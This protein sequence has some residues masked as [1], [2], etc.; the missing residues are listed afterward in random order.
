M[1]AITR[2]PDT[3]IPLRSNVNWQLVSAAILVDINHNVSR[4]K[5]EAQKING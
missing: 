2:F 1:A 4:E 3:P 5:H